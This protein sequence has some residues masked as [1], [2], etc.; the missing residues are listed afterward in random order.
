MHPLFAI[1]NEGNIKIRPIGYVTSPV[2][3]SQTGGLTEVE[4]TIVLGE[5]C[6]N[7]LDGIEDFSHIVVLY[8]LHQITGYR[9]SC[10]PQG[11]MDVP[12]LGMLA[13]R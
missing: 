5:D 12:L 9:E 3:Q 10:H 2:K 8:W 11:K 6:R 13:T 7:C 1:D 4:A